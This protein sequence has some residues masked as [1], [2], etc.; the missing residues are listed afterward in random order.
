MN[1]LSMAPW[2][3]CNNTAELTLKAFRIFFQLTEITEFCTEF[4]FALHED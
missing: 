2:R 1:L 3:N 4:K